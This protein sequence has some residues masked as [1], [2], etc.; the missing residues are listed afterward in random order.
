[1]FH[2]FSSLFRCFCREIVPKVIHSMIKRI[3]MPFV[4]IY[5]PSD[6]FSNSLTASSGLL[7]S[8]IF[9]RTISS[10]L[11]DGTRGLRWPSFTFEVLNHKNKSSKKMSLNKSSYLNTSIDLGNS[12]REREK[13]KRER[14]P[15]RH[16]NNC[17][18]N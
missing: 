2:K 1:M 16:E 5:M 18:Q 14:K 6:Y 10:I 15:C 13:R 3:N 8:K 11:L 12:A 7:L 9:R 4:F 17:L